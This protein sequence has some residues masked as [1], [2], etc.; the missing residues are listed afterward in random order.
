MRPGTP[1]FVGARL[2]EA[3]EARDLTGVALADIVGVTRAAISQYERERQSPSPEAMRKIAECL[4]L[5]MQFFLCRSPRFKPGTVFY[6]SMSSATKRARVRA[7]RRYGWLHDIVDFLRNYVRFREVRVPD[8]GLPTDPTK[9]DDDHIEKLAEETRRSWGLG[10]GPI[11]NVTWLLENQGAVV[12]RCELGAATL[13]AFSEWSQTDSSPYV[14]LNS[15]KESA[16]RSRFDAAHEL[17]HMILHRHLHESLL[18]QAGSFSLIETQAHRFASAFLLPAK[19]FSDELYSPSLDGFRTLKE[20]WRVSIGAMIKRAAQLGIIGEAHERRLWMNIGRR[21]WRT[22]EPLD[23]TLKPE[24]PCFL[25][26][27]VE[28]LITK[29]II[30]PNELPL[31]LALAARDI[32]ELTG[33]DAGYLGDTGPEIELTG[34]E[35]IERH[36]TPPIIQFPNPSSGN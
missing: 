9:I 14:I 5:P 32:E 8:F 12:T 35:T 16:A 17:G 28:L 25:R 18:R 30:S 34:G 26:R 29:G 3:R 23:D 15:E 19:T 10:L 4:N 20:K 33:L 21:K 6:R 7:E 13:D 31:R 22:K 2:R 24:Q 1:G 36:D 11:S 27:S